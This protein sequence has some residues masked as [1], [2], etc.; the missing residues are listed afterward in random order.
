M[1]RSFG[2]PPL[3]RGS[4]DLEKMQNIRPTTNWPST[5][6]CLKPPTCSQR[7]RFGATP[8]PQISYKHIWACRLLVDPHDKQVYLPHKLLPVP[9]QDHV[10][11]IYQ[12]ESFG[13]FTQ[14]CSK[15]EF[16]HVVLGTIFQVVSFTPTSYMGSDWRNPRRRSA[17]RAAW[18]R[19]MTRLTSHP[20]GSA[21]KKL[22]GK[23]FE[24]FSFRQVVTWR[25]GG[26]SQAF[27]SY[28]WMAI[29][30]WVPQ[31]PVGGTWC[32][33]QWLGKCWIFIW[34]N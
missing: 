14:W 9:T 5:A 4:K 30:T 13:S 27:I 28:E 24:V 8:T 18:A 22:W 3:K 1:S 29:W 23:S 11:V 2:K 32:T 31:P 16:C 26:S 12:L 7:E 20:S 17:I 34:T 33:N 10:P 21:S 19:K 25:L 15:R 6:I